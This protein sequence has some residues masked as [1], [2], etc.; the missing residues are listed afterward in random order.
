LLSV[1][2]ERIRGQALEQVLWER[3]F[4]PVD[5]V[6]TLLLRRD[7]DSIPNRGSQHVTNPDGGFERLYW[8]M[9]CLFWCGRY[10]F[11]GR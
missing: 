8:G 9:D 1:A 4:R 5:M 6:D 10:R 2:I 7:T 3:I 11:H